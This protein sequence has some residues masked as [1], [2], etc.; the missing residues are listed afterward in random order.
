M[1]RVWLR[2]RLRLLF[3]SWM[4]LPRCV[5]A[6]DLVADASSL[7]PLLLIRLPIHGAAEMRIIAA[8]LAADASSLTPL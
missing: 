2:L 5:T 1:I 8:D 7:T 4:V 6:A 3:I